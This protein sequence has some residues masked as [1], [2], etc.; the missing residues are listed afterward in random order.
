L[1]GAPAPPELSISPRF[2]LPPSMASSAAELGVSV[3][4]MQQK[5]SA[6]F[7]EQFKLSQTLMNSHSGDDNGA[8]AAGVPAQ[9]TVA[10]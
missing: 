2:A 1:Q 7:F 8:V 10:T 5:A 6:A 4:L 3:G 9:E